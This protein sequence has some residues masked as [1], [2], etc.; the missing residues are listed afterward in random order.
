[1]QIICTYSF[2]IFSS[3]I[4][5]LVTYPEDPL[6]ASILRFGIMVSLKHG[7]R[8]RIHK[9]SILGYGKAAW[10]WDIR[11]SGAGFTDGYNLAGAADTV[12]FHHGSAAYIHFA[13]YHLDA[14]SCGMLS[15]FIFI[16]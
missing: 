4:L 3:F 5:F 14:D 7:N 11:Y 16:F 8:S 6:Y 1:M 13:Q 12:I 10:L 9:N 15:F 2:V